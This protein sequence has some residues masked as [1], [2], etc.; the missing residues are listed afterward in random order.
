MSRRPRG[1]ALITVMLVAALASVIAF[2]MLTRH[3]MAVAKT[4]QVVYSNQALNYALGA[5]AYA[6]QML[7]ADFEAESATSGGAHVDSADDAWANPMAPF[8]VEQGEIEIQITDLDGL[9]NLNSLASTTSAQ[10]DHLRRFRNLLI[11]LKLDPN[12]ADVVVDWVD[13]DL[14]IS[15]FGAEDGQYLL[16]DPAYRVANTQFASVSE[17]RLLPGI[18]SDAYSILAPY[19]AAL[20][21]VNGHVNINSV[22]APVLRSFSTELDPGKMESIATGEQVYETVQQLVAEV[23]ELAPFTSLLEVRSRFFRINV[24]SS[25]ADQ[26]VR[27]QSI[28][29]R[30]PV[31]GEVLVISREFGVRFASRLYEEGEEF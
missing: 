22:E 25:Y 23:P 1:V 21:A 3:H 19:V 26:T 14:E 15:G 27:M 5:E 20:P 11:D 12:I 4:R 8:E 6:V 9:F 7:Y 18:D 30:N 13:E 17:L 31:D 2:N 10:R 16:R 29:H 24:R 28:V